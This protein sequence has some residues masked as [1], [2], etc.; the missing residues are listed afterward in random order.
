MN[1]SAWI[2]RWV[3]P[4]LAAVAASAGAESP[5]EFDDAAARMQ[6][7]FYTGDSR[8]LEEVLIEIAGFEVGGGLAAAKS[9]QLA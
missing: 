6:F 2:R 1:C 3:L 4:S 8:A 5:A 9:Y 7:A